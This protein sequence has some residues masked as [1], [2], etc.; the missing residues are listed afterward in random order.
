MLE[1]NEQTIRQIINDIESN[2]NKERKQ[3]DFKSHQI[4]AGRQREY[5]KHELYEIYPESRVQSIYLEA[6]DARSYYEKVN[7]DFFKTKFRVRWYETK[8]G[9]PYSDDNQVP[10]FLEKKMK[11]GAKRLKRRCRKKSTS[12]RLT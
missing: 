12:F 6:A 1:L 4:F 2:Q 10:V 7:S 11:V 8:E 5:V 9:R 3:R